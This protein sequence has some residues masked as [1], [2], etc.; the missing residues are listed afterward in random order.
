ML[1]ADGLI[2]LN[3]IAH[4]EG[5]AIG[6]RVKYAKEIIVHYASRDNNPIYTICREGGCLLLDITRTGQS[7]HPWL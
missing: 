6:C 4:V 2:V 1:R 3:I 7:Y 5:I